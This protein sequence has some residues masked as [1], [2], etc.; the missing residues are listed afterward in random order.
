MK[1][2]WSLGL[3]ELQREGKEGEREGRGETALTLVLFLYFGWCFLVFFSFFS[4]SCG[5]EVV[6]LPS[7]LACHA[8][9]PPSLAHAWASFQLVSIVATAGVDKIVE[10]PRSLFSSWCSLLTDSRCL[11]F[12][13]N[14]FLCWLPI[15]SA[16]KKKT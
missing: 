7:S 11:G 6:C 10:T 5:N 14:V 4:S 12:S 8:D 3:E 2:V 9:A 16:K 1:L 13:G 15:A